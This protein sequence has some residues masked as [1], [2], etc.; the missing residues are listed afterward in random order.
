VNWSDEDERAAREAAA[1]ICAGERYDCPYHDN[2][3]PACELA[4]AAYRAIRAASE[5][6]RAEGRAS[7]LER[8]AGMLAVWASASDLGRFYTRNAAVE[9]L[10]KALR[11][12]F[13][14]AWPA[15]PAKESP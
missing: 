7:A 14:P 5:S 9:S 1:D 11:A 3:P 12:A 6:G 2:S 10:T 8:V 13:A 15:L 4:H